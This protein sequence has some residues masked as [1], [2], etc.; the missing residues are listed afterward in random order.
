[1]QIIQGYRN[2]LS[3]LCDTNKPLKIFVQINGTADY[4]FSFFGLDNNDYLKK[5]DYMIFYNQLVSPNKEMQL[6]LK[7]NSACITINLNS[8]PSDIHKIVSTVSIDGEEKMSQIKSCDFCL[9]Q[10]NKEIANLHLEGSQFK[11]EKAIIGLEL[12]LKD[13]IWRLN[14]VGK[15]FDGGL[16]ALLENFGGTAVKDEKLQNKRASIELK[17]GQKVNLQKSSSSLG[18][19]LINLNWSQPTKK[20]E[21][22]AP[23]FHPIDLDLACL[24]ELKNG[25]KG[26]IQALGNLFGNLHKPPYIE[27]DKDDRTGES[28]GGEN[29]YVNGSMISHIKRILVYTF[30]YEGIANWREA[31]GVVTIKCPGSQ[32]IIVRMDEYN[33]NKTLCAIALFENCNDET[34]SVEKIVQFFDNQI[35]MDRKFGWG[36]RWG[37]P[38]RK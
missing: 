24:Y 31:D 37:G 11:N 14:A 21:F 22:F 9:M 12:Y 35:P 30:I 18:E 33:S 36:L 27:L 6:E 26:C 2:K 19:I 10:S 16:K 32:N 7:E 1:M 28:I 5:E 13:D 3:N 38:G 8:L 25:S 17:K 29:L 4:D 34:F 15:G 20:K 23:K